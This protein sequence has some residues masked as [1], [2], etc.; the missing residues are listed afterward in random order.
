VILRR[1]LVAIMLLAA[2]LAACAGGGASDPRP[3]ATAR[4]TVDAFLQAAAD[5]NLTR[6]SQLWGTTRGPARTTGQPNDYE[7]RVFIMQSYLRGST[8]RVVADN[9]GAA[10]GQRVVHVQIRRAD[11]VYMVPFTAVRSNSGTWVVN[12]FDLDILGTPGRPCETNPTQS[13]QPQPG[14]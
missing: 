11:C 8:H 6:M 2:P 9:P 3:M 12:S 10:E 5:S 7:K 4:E 1:T 14:Q 13:S